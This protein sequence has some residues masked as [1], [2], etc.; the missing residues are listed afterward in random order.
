MSDDE[1]DDEYEE[2]GLRDSSFSFDVEENLDYG[3]DDKDIK[4]IYQSDLSTADEN[5]V[6]GV[7]Q[8]EHIGESDELGTSYMGP[9][10]F[11]ILSSEER[12]KKLLKQYK[13]KHKEFKLLKNSNIIELIEKMKKIEYKNPKAFL[14]AYYFIQ[15]EEPQKNIEKVIGKYCRKNIVDKDA[16]DEDEDDDDDDDTDVSIIDVIRYIRMIR[17]L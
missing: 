6:M 5:F 7:K 12:F 4:T 13:D 2:D 1:Y 11:L 15:T 3:K 16:D 9:R 10:S 17:N 14:L 8:Y